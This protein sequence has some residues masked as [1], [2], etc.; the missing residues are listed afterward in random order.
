MDMAN[1][2]L[3]EQLGQQVASQFNGSQVTANVGLI[4]T[5]P[6]DQQ[7]VVRKA[8][9]RSLRTAWI[10]VRGTRLVSPSTSLALKLVRTILFLC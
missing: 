4:A 1:L 9:F 8:Y 6:Q 5:L 10:M 7:A 3:V 2:G